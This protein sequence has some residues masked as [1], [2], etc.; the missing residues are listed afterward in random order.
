MP[1][2]NRISAAKGST[3][4]VCVSL[5]RG[6]SVPG[7]KSRSEYPSLRQYSGQLISREE[8][9]VPISHSPADRGRRSSELL[10]AGP[11]EICERSD[12]RDQCPRW[13]ITSPMLCGLSFTESPSPEA[14]AGPPPRP[15]AA[16]PHAKKRSSAAGVL[17]TNSRSGKEEFREMCECA[18]KKQHVCRRHFA[19]LRSVCRLAMPVGVHVPG[20]CSR[21]QQR[22]LGT[23]TAAFRQ[24][25]HAGAGSAAGRQRRLPRL[26][27]GGNSAMRRPAR[28]AAQLLRAVPPRLC[29][30]LIVNAERGN[31]SRQSTTRV[32]PTATPISGELSA[33]SELASRR[34]HHCPGAQQHAVH[35]VQI[36]L[37]LRGK[38]RR[39]STG[40]VHAVTIMRNIIAVRRHV[41]NR[42]W[43][44][45]RSC[46]G[47]LGA[48]PA[49][50]A[51]GG[52]PADCMGGGGCS[53]ALVTTARKRQRNNVGCGNV[54]IAFT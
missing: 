41:S 6:V 28:A 12:S 2:R 10:S 50:I 37:R 19:P 43:M 15:G 44:L 9:G 25:L 46:G 8:M 14:P 48:Y 39:V 5:S 33:S 42:R 3:S 18:S 49:E 20:C 30:A 53:A 38:Y 11:L 23:F 17:V 47:S 31:P 1:T 34:K 29:P 27:T 13:L 35:K 7:K 26:C 40:R 4:I 24:N 32:S 36:S 21:I 52:F 45:R 22:S 51:L 54:H 16:G